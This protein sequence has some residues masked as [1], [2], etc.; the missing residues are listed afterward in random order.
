MPKQKTSTPKTPAKS[1]GFDYAALIKAARFDPVWFAREVLQLKVLPGEPTIDEDPD[2]AWELDGWQIEMLQAAGD[3]VRKVYNKPTVC[4]HDGVPLITVR[5]CQ[6][7]GKTFGAAVLLHWFQFCFPAL[8]V[9][10]A[11]KLG[12]VTGRLWREFIKIQGRAI[13]GYSSL[14]D[15]GGKSIAWRTAEERFLRRW[16][17]IAETASTPESL[18]G[19]HEKY[20][21]V[22]IDEASGVLDQMAAVMRGAMSTGRVVLAL[23]IGNPNKTTGFFAD[24]HRRADLAS[25]YYRMRVSWENSK[26]V[27]RSWVEQMVRQY[28]NNSPVV[29]IRCY[30][31]FAETSELQLIAPE[32]IVDAVQREWPAEGDGSMTRLRMSIDVA[33]GGEDETVITIARHWQ[34]VVEVLRVYRYSFETAHAVP[35]AFEEAVRLWEEWSFNTQRG[36]DIVVDSMGVGSGVAGLLLRADFP[37]IVYKGGESASNPDRYRNRRVQSY[38]ALRNA[39]RDGQM[40]LRENAVDDMASFEAQLCSVQMV[41]GS[42]RRVEDLVTKEQMKRDGIKSPDM[43]DSLAMQF[44]TQAPALQPGFNNSPNLAPQIFVS[45]LNVLRGYSDV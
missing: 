35:K 20:L 7:P 2:G 22:I 21:L 9:C 34:S 28:G 1:R 18:Q 17:A 6:G 39:F 13:P 42:D 43:A 38:I 25:D 31:D 12:Q 24:S 14:M 32:W 36:D 41:P 5:A 27:K 37:T 33:D 10:T 16:I 23:I 44:A 11:P 29:K 8:A 30:G 40:I 45:P 19:F 26:R 3:V 15:V 4:N